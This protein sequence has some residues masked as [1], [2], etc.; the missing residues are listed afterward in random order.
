[1][2]ETARKPST[3]EQRSAMRLKRSSEDAA[4]PVH[5][6]V[7][8]HE[9]AWPS[10]IMGVPVKSLAQKIVVLALLECK[11]TPGP[12]AELCIVL[13]NDHE[14]QQL[15]DQ[16][17][18]KPTTTNVL[19]FP[20]IAPFAPVE[21]MLGDIILAHETIVCEAQRQDKTFDH[22]F[23]HLLTHGFLHILGY[24]HLNEPDAKTMEALEIRILQ[25]LGISDPYEL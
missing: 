20:Q 8:V 4:C 6:D 11:I 7:V 12:D 23:A 19:S 21:G 22:H 16:W 13:S 1:M 25:Q 24:D 3:N 14:Q 9:N 10:R 5:I 2:R 15:N 17:R 18:S